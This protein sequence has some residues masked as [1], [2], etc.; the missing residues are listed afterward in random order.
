MARAAQDWTTYVARFHEERPGVTEDVLA[1]SFSRGRLTPYTW[2]TA[3]VPFGAR[4]LDLACGSGPNLRLRSCEP[5]IGLDRSPGEVR[6]ARASGAPHVFEGEATALPFADGT[7]DAVICSMALMIMDPLTRVLA[8]VR[9]VLAPGGLFVMTI[10]G[11]RPLRARDVARYAQLVSRLGLRRLDYP[12]LRPFARAAALARA[13]G[14]VVVEDVRARFD[15]AVTSSE[16]SALFVRSLYLPG[17][18][19]ERVNSAT[20]LADS[21]IDTSIGIPLRRLTMVR[22]RER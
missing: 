20:R 15:Y 18:S 11:H 16:R 6:R 9:R 22:A 14:F 1:A 13:N 19:A 8:E 21:W 10:P 5:W 4:T 17:V 2:I 3:P 7:F 12:N